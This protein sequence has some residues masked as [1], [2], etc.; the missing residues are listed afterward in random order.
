MGTR[1]RLLAISDLH[2]SSQ[3]NWQF[4]VQ[5][6]PTTDEDWLLL[7][8]DV[9][10]RAEDIELV[11]RTLS[12]RFAKVVWVP[13]HHE[14]WTVD[15][16]SLRLR[17]EARYRHLVEMCRSV[18]V[19]TPEDPYP[20]W[21]GPGGPLVVVP[22]FLLYDYTFR[23]EGTA[24]KAQALQRAYDAGVV[25]TD[26]FRLFPDPYP[27]RESWCR[28]RVAETERRLTALDPALSTVL[29]SHWPLLREPTR[30]LWYRELALWC[31]TE[32]TADWHRRFRAA[33]V[34]YGHLHI[35]RTTFHDGVRFEEVSVGYPREWRRRGHPQ[36]ALR[37]VLPARTLAPGA[38]LL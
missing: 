20:V 29:V 22:L 12:Q 15:D 38:P 18:G 32:L 1:P 26:E 37:D 34:V 31:G 35:P 9:S 3:E 21:Q 25:C 11:L 14:L 19:V 13:G 17:G 4:V 36:G 10:E 5:A 16:D 33:A 28:A 30:V 7:A 8:G 2:V 27:D 23:P 24:T 6:R